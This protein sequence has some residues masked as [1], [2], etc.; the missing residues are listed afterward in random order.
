MCRGKL[1]IC[2][3]SVSSVHLPVTLGI[4]KLPTAVPVTLCSLGFSIYEYNN[5]KL[6]DFLLRLLYLLLLIWTKNE[7]ESL[8]LS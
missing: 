8:Y 4:Q 5:N 7:K 1:K 3:S 2:I 6:L